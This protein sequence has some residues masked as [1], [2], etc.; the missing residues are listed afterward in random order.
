MTTLI[1]IECD[2]IFAPQISGSAD[3]GM[4]EDCMPDQII[5]D[6]VATPASKAVDAYIIEQFN[7]E[8]FA[9]Y[10]VNAAQVTHTAQ[11]ICWTART[12]DSIKATVDGITAH[13]IGNPMHGLMGYSLHGEDCAVYEWLDAIGDMLRTR[14]EAKL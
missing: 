10:G 12:M 2:E 11:M 6:E 14:F 9:E 3:A 13:A 8:V 1:C 4:C 5:G 7:A